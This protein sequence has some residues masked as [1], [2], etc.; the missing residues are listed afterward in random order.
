MSPGRVFK[1]ANAVYDLRSRSL[2][3]AD[4]GGAVDQKEP[5]EGHAGVRHTGASTRRHLYNS[6]LSL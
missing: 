1:E 2:L 6:K 5:T 3:F 4:K